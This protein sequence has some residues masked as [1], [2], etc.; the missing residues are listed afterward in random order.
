MGPKTLPP[1]HNLAS[2][3]HQ[4]T[5]YYGRVRT[6]TLITMAGPASGPHFYSGDRRTVWT[7]QISK[8]CEEDGVLTMQA[9]VLNLHKSDNSVSQAC[10]QR[11][12]PLRILYVYAFCAFCKCSDDAR[13]LPQTTHKYNPDG[14]HFQFPC[15]W[16]ACP[17]MLN[18][19]PGLE[20]LIL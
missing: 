4:D 9:S 14:A 15:V 12:F 5:H 11:V 18:A 16:R 1:I 19:N 6:G 7:L 13:H 10:A 3:P 20:S 2:G 17:H 8:R